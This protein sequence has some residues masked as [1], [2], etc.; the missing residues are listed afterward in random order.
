[1]VKDKVAEAEWKY[2]CVNEHGQQ[3]KNMMETAQA[4]S[5]LSKSPCSHKETWLN[6]EL[7]KHSG[8]RSKSMEIG[9][10]KNQQ[11]HEGVQEE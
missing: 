3:M 11:R 1:M 10:K 2:L 7:L 5:G 4:T 9:R 6:E 8:K